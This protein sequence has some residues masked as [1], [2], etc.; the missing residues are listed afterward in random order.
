MSGEAHDREWC[1]LL[2]NFYLFLALLFSF[3]IADSFCCKYVGVLVSVFSVS[4]TWHLKVS[5]AN[6]NWP[7][8]V[9]MSTLGSHVEQ[10]CI[11]YRSGKLLAQSCC[12]NVGFLLLSVDLFQM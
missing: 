8:H 4:R 5:S 9:R 3:V 7:P 11:T 2:V 1:L 12:T 6:L 10:N